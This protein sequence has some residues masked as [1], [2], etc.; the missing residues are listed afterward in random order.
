MGASLCEP[1]DCSLDT[2]IK[3][4]EFSPQ[5]RS[6]FGLSAFRVLINYGSYCTAHYKVVLYP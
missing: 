6:G 4:P 2:G 3:E 5:I 1:A